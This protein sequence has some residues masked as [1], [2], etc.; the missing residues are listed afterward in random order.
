MDQSGLIWLILATGAPALTGIATLFLPKASVTARTLVAALGPASAAA[1][2]LILAAQHGVGAGV[3]GVPLVPSLHLNLTFHADAL[4]L[5]FGLLVSVAGTL[6]VFY[7]RG[8]FGKDRAALFRFYPTLGFF[9]TAM[10]GV[11]LTDDLLAMLLFWELTSLSSFLLIGW[12][13]DNP[14]ATRLAVQALA[15]TGLG[16]LA[17]LGGLILFAQAT[18]EWSFSG[19]AEV[20]A[21][22]D[23]PASGL[24]PVAFALMFLGGA[25]K[26]AQW[27]FHYWLPGAMA[28]PTPVSAYLH[29]ATMVKA[30]IYLFG[31]L[32]PMLAALASWAPTLTV[33]GAVTLLLGAYLALRAAELKKVFAY[34]TVSQ[35]GL[36]TCMYGLGA[37]PHEGEANLIWPVTQI[38][39]HA[40]YKAPLFLMA[41]AIMHIVGRKEWPQLRGLARTRPV[42]AWTTLAALYAMAGGPLTLSFT[43]K[44]AFLYQAYHALASAPWVWAVVVMTILAAAFNVAIFVRFLTTFLAR[45]SAET[46]ARAE[47]DPHALEDNP[48]THNVGHPPGDDGGHHP[49][50]VEPGFWGSCL[51]WPAA[52]IV[53]WQFVG[54]VAPGLFGEA[55]L[56]VETHALVW[57]RLPGFLYAISHPS[58]PLLFS[59]VAIGLGLA[60]GL[61]PAL[62]GVRADPHDAIFPLASAGLER[63]GWRIFATVQTGNFRHYVYA[64][65]AALL[66]GLVASAVADP[67]WLMWP[68]QA[69]LLLSN[70]GIMIAGSCM[71]LLICATAI[72]LPLVTSRIVRVL[73]LGACGLSV[74]GLYLLY[75]APDLAL[76][77]LMFE[78]ISVILFLLVLRML[79]EE[80]LRA[81]RVGMAGRVAFSSLVG[82]AV[83][84][85]VLQ[86]G[87]YADITPGPQKLGEWFLAHAY[88]GT[89]MTGGRGGGGANTVNVILVDFRGYDTLGEITVLS[90]A[91][92]GVFAVLAAVPARRRGPTGPPGHHATP[93]HRLMTSDLFRTSMRLILPLSLIF[94][95]YVFFKGHNAPGGGFIAG[96]VTAVSLAVYRMAEGPLALK[97][98]LP[99]KPGLM[100]AMGL[101]LA[102]ATA[103]TPLLFDLPL[104]TSR[105]ATIPLTGGSEYH[106]TSV[107][108]FDL[109]V[110]IVVVAVSVG[111][112]NRLTEELEA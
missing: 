87:A 74:T 6:I 82:V 38:L 72:A 104:L 57:D 58:M 11:V 95:A 5:F 27:P 96:L 76:T 60:I 29:S 19:A 109:G 77:Q 43:A 75:Q 90:I 110:L 71:T 89:A 88:E 46:A 68:D 45:P 13:R 33:I 23:L 103:A 35:L 106:W 12:E 73:V 10:M 47:H 64:V 8:Y 83:G 78:I 92:I 17:L 34:S 1:A 22:G 26:S 3:V 9:A 94:A 84:W 24:L 54:G 40:L 70:A 21:S 28:A 97:R 66:V 101:L 79:P 4:G 61:G 107:L 102:L 59:A 37:L 15:T 42:L 111:M 20:M 80:G 85:I 53:L 81:S 50:E 108:F 69:P 25:A 100:A 41:G 86:A 112:I 99:I 105:H 14:K 7:A 30:G 16:G 93:A 44:E 36:F 2:L 98:L 51:V 39:N 49:H 31:R 67:S 18:G 63:L 52:L 32:F 65:L 48:A 91:A 56:P 62:R 55:V